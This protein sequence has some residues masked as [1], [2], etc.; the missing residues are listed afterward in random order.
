MLPLAADEDVHGHILRGLRLREP[1]ID[2]VRIQDA[3]LAGSIDPVILEWAAK[4]GRVLITQDMRTMIGYAWA[5][6]KARQS[7]PGVIVRD[8]TAV[9]IRQAIDDLLVI[10]LCSAA[11]DFKDQVF[12]LPL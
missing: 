7:M 9:T 2:L 1:H 11:D 3:G 12:Y 10:A 8:E 5:R 4:E 6:V